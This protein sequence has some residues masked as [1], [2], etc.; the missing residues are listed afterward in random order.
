LPDGVLF[1]AELLREGYA[2]A[3]TI[4]P[5]VK[6]AG[7]FTRLAR[8]AREKGRGLWGEGLQSLSAGADGHKRA[9]LGWYRKRR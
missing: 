3:L 6:Y 2:R 7:V 8:E 5:N 4:P 1:N 9:T